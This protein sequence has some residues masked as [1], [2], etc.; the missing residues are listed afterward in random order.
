MEI[1]NDALMKNIFREPLPPDQWRRW[2]EKEAIF[3]FTRQLDS[4]LQRAHT[5]VNHK[6]VYIADLEDAITPGEPFGDCEDYVIDYWTEL[7]RLGWP[8]NIG[9]IT[10]C[11]VYPGRRDIGYHAVL[12][13]DTNKGTYILDQRQP[14]PMLWKD[15]AYDWHCRSALQHLAFVRIHQP[16]G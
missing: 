6:K 11:W 4:D 12:S 3:E 13:V 2:C 15:L 8:F 14:K 9:H 1:D 16:K 10:Y 7:I 5:N